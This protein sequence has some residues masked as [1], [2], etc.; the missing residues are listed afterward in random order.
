MRPA[1]TGQPATAVGSRREMSSDEK[2]WL[3]SIISL[4]TSI[5][6]LVPMS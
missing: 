1:E 2:D 3:M 5:L 4:Q 6:K